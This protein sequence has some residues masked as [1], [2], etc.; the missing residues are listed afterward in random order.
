MPMITVSE[1]QQIIH[2]TQR[3]FG[4]ETVKLSQALG[5]VLREPLQADRDFPPFDRSIRDGIAISYQAFAEGRRSFDIAGTAPA[6]SPQAILRDP[7]TCMEIMTGAMLPQGADTVI[8]YEDVHIVD[9]TASIHLDALT[10][11]QYIHPQGQDRKAHS[12]IV[13]AGTL[14][15]PAE[16]GIAATVGQDHLTV[17][18]LPRTVIVSTGDEL[19]SV[20]Q[21]PLPYQIRRSNSYTLQA[22]L[23]RWGVNAELAHLPD[24]PKAIESQLQVMLK[25]FDL[26]MLSG[27]VSKGKFD[28]LPTSLQT[29]GAE[30]HFHKVKQRPGKPLWFGSHPSGPVVFALPG[31]PVSSFMCT[32]RYILPW[33]T[34]SLGLEGSTPT[35]ARLAKEVSFKPDLTYFVQVQAYTDREGQ[36][37]AKPIEGHGSGDLANLVEVDGF[38]ELPQGPN[39]FAEGTSY[40]FWPF[41]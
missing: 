6:G 41:R 23:A 3:S 36:L 40:R 32:I 18:R 33:L 17:A 1:A 38:L 27:G 21:T 8:Q 19:V 31:N 24:E 39:L 13:Q 25:E 35:Y 7:H 16:L 34:V 22:T 5:R 4:V 10:L 9:G 29:L 28:F 30:Q 2:Q 26:I 12:M 11:G 15:S 20:D 37:W 14:L